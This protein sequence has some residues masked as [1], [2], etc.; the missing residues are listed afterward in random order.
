MMEK[1]EFIKDLTYE[2]KKSRPAFKPKRL[3]LKPFASLIMS[4]IMI[5]GK[6]F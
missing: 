5:P 2:I 4:L 3:F 6:G 1:I